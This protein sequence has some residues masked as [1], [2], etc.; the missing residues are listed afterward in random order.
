MYITKYKPK[1]IV[2]RKGSTPETFFLR[3]M[4][5]KNGDEF[6][7]FF[8]FEPMR[9]KPKYLLLRKKMLK[10]LCSTILTIM[11]CYPVP[12]RNSKIGP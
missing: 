2:K 7:F 6:L 3:C 4:Y 12:K 8:K 1:N 10:T 9:S 5:L 11:F